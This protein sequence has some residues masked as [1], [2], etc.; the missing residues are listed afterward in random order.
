LGISWC[1]SMDCSISGSGSISVASLQAVVSSWAYRL[2]CGPHFTLG[3]LLRLRPE[4]TDYRSHFL[5]LISAI[6]HF[7]SLRSLFLS[8]S[9][10]LSVSAFILAIIC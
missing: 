10:P 6:I 3:G 1:S 2:Y 4:C 8:A 9:I 5:A 7:K